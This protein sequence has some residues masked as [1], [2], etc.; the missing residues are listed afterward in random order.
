MEEEA[1]ERGVEDEPVKGSVTALEQA[2]SD[3]DLE[4]LVIVNKNV[5]SPGAGWEVAIGHASDRRN[6]RR[7][8]GV[9]L[10]QALRMALRK[11]KVLQQRE[12]V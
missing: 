5:K 2:I 11:A 1:T 10:E 12:G 7:G 3:M 6:A 8:E 4:V 9:T